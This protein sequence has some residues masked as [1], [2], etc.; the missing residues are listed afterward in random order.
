MFAHIIAYYDEQFRLYA[1]DNEWY[2]ADLC[3][4]AEENYLELMSDCK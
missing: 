4:Q 2:Q 3:A 1:R